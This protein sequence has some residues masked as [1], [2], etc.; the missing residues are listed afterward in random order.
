MSSQTN[1]AEDPDATIPDE[2]AASLE[3]SKA[4]VGEL[5]PQNKPPTEKEAEETARV[6]EYALAGRVTY[7]GKKLRP[8]TALRHWYWCDLKVRMASKSE[9]GDGFIVLFV[10]SHPL[11]YLERV[12]QAPLNALQCRRLIVETANKRWETNAD[13]QEMR[14]L[15]NRVLRQVFNARFTPVKEPEDDSGNSPGQPG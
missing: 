14:E 11:D 9:A 12:V 1:T 13:E 8:Y 2:V 3:V 10:L 4:L 5:A 7:K 6:R 15:G